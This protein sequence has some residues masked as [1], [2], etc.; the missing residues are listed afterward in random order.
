MGA[1]QDWYASDFRRAARPMQRNLLSL[2]IY[3]LHILQLLFQEASVTKVAEREGI[4]QPAASRI[5]AKLRIQLSD[6]LLVKSGRGMVLTERAELLRYPVQEILA[7]A[8]SLDSDIAF[9]PAKAQQTF[10]IGCADCLLPSFISGVIHRVAGAGSRLKIRFKT[11]DP[12]FD[13]ARGLE[14]GVLDLIVNNH[15]KP[16]EDLRISPLYTE[17]VV[18]M[19]RVGH[20]LASYRRIGL[21]RYLAARHLAPNQSADGEGGPI[22][23]SMARAGYRREIAATVPEYNLVP[24]VLMNSDLVFTTGRRFAQEQAK[25][26]PLLILPAPSEFADLKFYQLWHP[27]KHTSASNR[28]LRQQINKV[29]QAIA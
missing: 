21:G 29:A 3:H 18:C 19:M 22:M 26:A 2:D 14:T 12:S 4:S 11:I 16:R 8:T 6:D 10:A 5:L 1:Y 15:P 17:E 27:R 20:P 9:D 23:S 7:H 25:L 28:W 13:A 24:H